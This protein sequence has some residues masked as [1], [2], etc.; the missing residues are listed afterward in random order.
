M[1]QQQF[2]DLTILV[3]RDGPGRLALEWTGRSNSRDPARVLDAFFRSVRDEAIAEGSCV[4]M[5]FDRLDFFNSA[6]ITALIQF[7]Q[8]MSRSNAKLVLVFDSTK[9]WQKLSFDVL[10]I[11]EK[12]DGLLELR[13][14]EA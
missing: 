10:R 5:R 2:G 11:F 7:V 12:A 1:E 6:T 4:E 8:E 9:R 13:P 3:H 14:M